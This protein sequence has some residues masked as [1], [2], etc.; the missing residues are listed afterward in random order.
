MFKPDTNVKPNSSQKID[1]LLLFSVGEVKLF[2]TRFYFDE[3]WL[4]FI[5]SVLFLLKLPNGLMYFIF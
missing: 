5:N 1:N 4:Y 3:I 2:G